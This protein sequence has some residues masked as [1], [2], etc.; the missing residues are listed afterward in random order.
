MRA[1][2]VYL[3]STSSMCKTRKLEFQWHATQCLLQFMKP[4]GTCG[5][6]VATSLCASITVTC[7]W[8]QKNVLVLPEPYWRYMHIAK[9]CTHATH[10][11][12]PSHAHAGT[13]EDAILYQDPP[14]VII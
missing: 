12:I 4:C 6:V 3:T 7:C 13:R 14:H 10:A 5:G 1:M 2:H 8:F 11:L 9:M